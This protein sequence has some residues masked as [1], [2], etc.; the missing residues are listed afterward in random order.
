MKCNCSW[1][2][3]LMLTG[4]SILYTLIHTWW[5]QS[6]WIPIH[7]GLTKFR[8]SIRKYVLPLQIKLRTQITLLVQI[9]Q[10]RPLPVTPKPFYYINQFPA[11]SNLDT[12]SA[13]GNGKPCCTIRRL[14]CPWFW[15]VSNVQIDQPV[16]CN[17]I[18]GL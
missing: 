12:L 13:I 6:P 17:A 10:A 14:L 15:P 7:S 5:G 9:C 18:M 2:H 3:Q 11:R 8:K 16:S 4:I 1:C